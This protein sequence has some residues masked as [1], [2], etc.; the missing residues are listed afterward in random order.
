[1]YI[2]MHIFLEKVRAFVPSVPVKHTEIA[3]TRPPAL[4]VGLGDV[5]DDRD[6]VFVIVFDQS[7]EGI[8]CVSFDGSV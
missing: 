5:H 1:M 8:D 2:F 4:E 3:A 6:A 7:V